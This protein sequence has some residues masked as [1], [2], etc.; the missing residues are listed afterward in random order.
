MNQQVNELRNVLMTITQ[1]IN[2]LDKRVDLAVKHSLR[3][4]QHSELA[5]DISLRQLQGEL[6]E[7][8]INTIRRLFSGSSPSLDEMINC[9]DEDYTE[10]ISSI[11]DIFNSDTNEDLE[12]KDTNEDLE[13][14]DT[15]TGEEI[16]DGILL[17]VIKDI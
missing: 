4:R 1:K 5:R 14:K 15:V 13:T 7:Q 12:T 6:Q 9:Q 11:I 10:S 2:S 17:D 3:A 16:L 8:E